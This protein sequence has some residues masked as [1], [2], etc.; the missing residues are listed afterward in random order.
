MGS[1]AL[2]IYRKS[3]IY[4]K[5]ESDKIIKKYTDTELLDFLQKL[6]DRHNFTGM[7][8]LR[9]SVTG[10]GWR[11]HETILSGRKYNVREAIIKYMRKY[12]RWN[13]TE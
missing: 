11:L 8:I 13:R 7:C 10:R 9:E 3:G 5:M 6:N 1:F 12:E 4:I 2:R